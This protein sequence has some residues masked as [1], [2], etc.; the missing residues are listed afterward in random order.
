MADNVKIRL[1][2]AFNTL[3]N[4]TEKSGNLRKDLKYDIVDSVSILRSIFGNLRNSVEE[5]TKINQLVGEL[6]T[7]KAKLMDS[8]IANLPGRTQP[9]RSGIR[10]TTTS[11]THYQLPPRGQ[12]K[13]LYF[14]AVSASAEKRY[15]L[16]VKSKLN[17]STEEAKNVLRTNVNPTVMKVG[18][19]TLKSLKDGRN[20]IEAGTTEEINKLS[21]TIKDKCVGGGELEVTL[22]YRRKPRMSQRTLHLIT[23][24]EQ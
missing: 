18:T 5:Q 9:S 2:R 12:P 16:M 22:P 13:K 21:Q 15:K 6:N 3:L 4:I 8:R 17:L 23:W 20:L 14:E 11:A 19:R 7:A 10:R 1:E 24:R